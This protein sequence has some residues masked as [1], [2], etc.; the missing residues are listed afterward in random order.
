MRERNHPLELFFDDFNVAPLSPT[1]VI[2]ITV[3]SF[4]FFLLEATLTWQ[5]LVS[6]RARVCAF[7]EVFGPFILAVPLL[8]TVRCMYGK[9][10]WNKITAGGGH[11]ESR[12]FTP[13]W[14]HQVDFILGFSVGYR[15]FES[16]K[17]YSPER[18]SACL[19]ADWSLSNARIGYARNK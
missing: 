17:G 6:V 2:I 7:E 8:P 10:G 14:R 5:T 15:M 16:Y 11:T 13:A 19:A 9:D 4:F 1:R 18:R 3:G 12:K